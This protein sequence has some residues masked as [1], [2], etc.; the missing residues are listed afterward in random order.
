M[1]GAVCITSVDS[2]KMLLT[3]WVNVCAKILAN[4]TILS[5]IFCILSLTQHYLFTNFF[6]CK[7]K[8]F[9]STCNI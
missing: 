4:T 8:P 6:I 7:K 5:F 2:Q 9:R 3:P 1:F